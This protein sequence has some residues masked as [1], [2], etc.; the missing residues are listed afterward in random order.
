MYFDEAFE[1]SREDAIRWDMERNKA[2]IEDWCKEAGV[3]EPVG[4]YNERDKGI[5]HIYTN[6]C[7]YLI[8]KMGCLVD[9][10]TERLSKEFNK[11]YTINFMEIKGGIVNYK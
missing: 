1:K 10:T 3:T 8:G 11:P 6:K 4:Y 9:K 7:G 2:I 5:L